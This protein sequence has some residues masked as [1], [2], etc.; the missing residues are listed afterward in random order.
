MTSCIIVCFSGRANLKQIEEKTVVGG[1]GACSPEKF[2]KFYIC[3]FS[4][5]KQT[6][7]KLSSPHS[8]SFT[9]YDA[10]C[11]HI[12]DLCVLASGHEWI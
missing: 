12:F 7:I 8:E 3:L 10:F 1:P 11:S 4:A 2:L 5:F 9:K 6:L